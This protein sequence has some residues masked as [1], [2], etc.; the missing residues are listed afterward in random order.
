MATRQEVFDNLL[1]NL[2]SQQGADGCIIVSKAGEVVAAKISKGFSQDKIAALAADAVTI[3]T[4]VI[5]E[6]NYGTPDTMVVES[7]RGKF[8][9]IAA[10]K[11]G[12]F[13]I[14]IGSETMNVGMLKMGLQD[15][16]SSF[17]AEM[18]R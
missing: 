12:V 16:I 14:V 7:N 11:A 17:D 15:A 10:E 18:S 2:G 8:A 13:I 5:T 6:L 1:N 4:K 9:M 3:A